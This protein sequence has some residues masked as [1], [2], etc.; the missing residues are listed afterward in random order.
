MPIEASAIVAT[1]KE[2]NA[3]RGLLGI[4]EIYF[5]ASEYRCLAVKLA[6]SPCRVDA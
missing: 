6:R 1:L 4:Y 2:R 5:E 3:E